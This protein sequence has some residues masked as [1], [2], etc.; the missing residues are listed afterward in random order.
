MYK[1]HIVQQQ[2]SRTMHVNEPACLIYLSACIY[3]RCRHTCYLLC[4]SRINKSNLVN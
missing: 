1:H 3:A 2:F 4:L